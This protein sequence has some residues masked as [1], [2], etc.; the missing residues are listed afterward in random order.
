MSPTQSS[1]RNSS[2]LIASYRR[3]IDIS[4]QLATTYDHISL[5]KKIVHAAK[6]LVN[7]EAVSIMLLD[8]QH[9]KLR[10]AAASN[11]KPHEMEELLIPIDSSIAGWIYTHGE[12][13]VI[14]DVRQERQHFQGVDN[15]LGFQSRNMLGVPMKA[16]EDVIG[17]M[18][19][20]NKE[21][22][23]VFTDD[24]VMILRTLAG[25]A[26]LAIENA[27]LFQQS[28]FI[29]EMVHELRTPL[30]ALRYSAVLLLRDGLS[31][32]KRRDVAVTMQRETERLITFTDDFL[33]IA[34]LESG[35]VQLEVA[36]FD[37]YELVAES[38]DVV[39]EQASNKQLSIEL[40][41]V[42]TIVE[43]D[44][45]K[46]KQVCLNLLTNAI[47]YNRPAGFIRVMTGYITEGDQNF[48]QVSVEDSGYGIEKEHQAHMFEK[49]YRVPATENRERGTGL[50]LAI[51]KHIVEAHGGRI[52]LESE[53]GVGSRFSF[54]LPTPETL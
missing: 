14:Q 48:V 4:Q 36:P 12:P 3:I 5:L 44:R 50:G 2:D 53:P 52:W 45:G 43:A 30:A 49:F 21:D 16:H 26:A 46:I 11:I 15:K 1:D 25:Q 22:G 20:M 19:A 31:E 6:E 47:K 41:A 37:I 35:R 9:N 54:S 39:N 51:C 24:D 7:V 23:A 42:R 27:R 18:Q 32:E 29:A 33:D 8:E 10:F 17:V 34:R 38:V 13:R 40:A 28:D